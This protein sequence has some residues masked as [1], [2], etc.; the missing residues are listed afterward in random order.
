MS[1]ASDFSEPF[2]VICPRCDG[3]FSPQ[4]RETP[5]FANCP[6][7]SEPVRVPAAAEVAD[8]WERARESQGYGDT[9]RLALPPGFEKSPEEVNFAPRPP[10]PKPPAKTRE[11]PPRSRREPE[12]PAQS[13]SSEPARKE[14][15][16]EPPAPLTVRA[17]CPACGAKFEMPRSDQ[18]QVVLCPECLEDVHLPAA[19]LARMEAPQELTGHDEVGAKD[20]ALP[21]NSESETVETDSIHFEEYTADPEAAVPVAEKPKKK[22]RRKPRDA[23][24]LGIP[25]ENPTRS[26]KPTKGVF[27]TLAE[28]RQV[29]E[30]PPPEW[31]FFSGVTDFLIRPEVAIRWVYA[32][33][34]VSVM[35]WMIA[36]CLYLYAA[37]PLALPFFILPLIWITIM[38]LS[39]LA[40]NS[41]AIL[42]ET[43]GGIDKIDGWPEP[44]TREQAVDLI[45]LSFIVIVAGVCSLFISKSLGLLIGGGWT[46]T[47]VVLFLLYP[48][49]LLSTLEANSPFVPLS[50]PILKSL[51]TVN[52]AW[53]VFYALSGGLLLVWVWPLLWMRE[54]SGWTQFFGM[55]FLSPLIAGWCLLYGRLLGR[56]AWRAS[57]EFPDDE[58]EDEEKN[59]DDKPKPKKRKKKPRPSESSGELQATR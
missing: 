48:I 59:P 15:A 29:G 45:Y 54:Q 56:L 53:G 57:L 28:V 33:L 24:P 38:T 47:L 40:A 9:Y 39:Y 50:L 14:S 8:E 25:A 20:F 18:P 51:K 27:D 46:L 17:G 22:K 31:T 4:V 43:A 23:E 16:T 36:M 49:I 2:S 35:G 13:Q 3:R 19:P 26:D 42:L 6:E 44:D 12:K 7:C 55:M 41:M 34:G 52:W 37:L 32:S 5:Y 11:Q 58:E 30:D 1:G 21:I 10:E